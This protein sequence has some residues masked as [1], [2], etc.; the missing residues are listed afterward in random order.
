MTILGV[1]VCLEYSGK[2]V[3]IQE[4]K[5]ANRLL[6]TLNVPAPLLGIEEVSQHITA[7][8]VFGKW[9]CWVSLCLPIPE[10]DYGE[11]QN[12][13]KGFGSKEEGDYLGATH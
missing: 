7:F 11:S 3:S 9:R 6:S 2:S 4:R 12:S 5:N 1:D 13:V 10:T 8:P